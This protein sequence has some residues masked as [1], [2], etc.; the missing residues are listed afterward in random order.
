MLGTLHLHGE[1]F[2]GESPIRFND[3]ILEGAAT[4]DLVIENRPDGVSVY[5]WGEN[6]ITLKE[7]EIIMPEKENKEKKD[8]EQKKQYPTGD[9]GFMQGLQGGQVTLRLF[10]QEF[11]LPI[12][13]IRHSD[14]KMEQGFVELNV[15]VNEIGEYLDSL[16]PNIVS[17]ILEDLGA[18]ISENDEQYYLTTEEIQIK[19]IVRLIPDTNGN[20]YEASIVGY[21]NMEG[22]LIRLEAMINHLINGNILVESDPETNQA[23]NFVDN[24]GYGANSFNTTLRR[25][26]NQWLRENMN[27]Q[28]ELNTSLDM[29][30]L[31][32]IQR[33]EL[34]F[35]QGDRVNDINIKLDQI[36]ADFGQATG[37]PATLHHLHIGINGLSLPEI[38]KSIMTGEFNAKSTNIEQVDI[39]KEKFTT[40]K[41]NN[42]SFNGFSLNINK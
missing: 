27:P 31:E 23:I 5:C 29:S 8:D 41:L 36:R 22:E 40:L 39:N 9:Y 18:N 30:Q 2:S 15:F 35:I 33:G 16:T 28:I 10:D 25:L 13:T 32:P 19:E 17:N 42:I 38:H 34:D 7:G 21:P 3:I 4:G 11:V 20:V 1:D 37:D 26:L 14:G 6:H 12:L 24:L